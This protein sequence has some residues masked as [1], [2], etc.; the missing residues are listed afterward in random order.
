MRCADEFRYA[1]RLDLIY[2]IRYD[3]IKHDAGERDGIQDGIQENIWV[4][5]ETRY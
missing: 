3:E 5:Y 4:R 2:E 1:M